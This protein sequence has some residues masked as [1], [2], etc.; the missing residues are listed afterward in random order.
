MKSIVFWSWPIAY[1][2]ENYIIVA[3]CALY[4]LKYAAWSVAEASLNSALSLILLV[5]L[6]IYPFAI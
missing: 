4:N 1:L 6:T 2:R 5:L 3:I